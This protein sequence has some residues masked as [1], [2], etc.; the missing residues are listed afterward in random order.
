MKVQAPC[1]LG[2]RFTCEKPFSLGRF[3][4]T[5]MTFFVWS[6]PESA[7]T[8]LD[9]KHDPSSSQEHC[10]FFHPEDTVEGIRIEFELPDEMFVPGYPLRNLGLNTDA[11]GRLH[12]IVLKEDGWNYYI[13]YGRQ[14]G[15]SLELV[16]TSR[17]DELFE[18]ILPLHA[19]Q[20]NLQDF[21]I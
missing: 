2:E 16:R 5:G 19:V 3:T 1:R 21:L 13:S 8:T 15:N 9:G 10:R 20:I 7:G 4:L 18:P 17:L 6:F 11:V 14:Y 12:G